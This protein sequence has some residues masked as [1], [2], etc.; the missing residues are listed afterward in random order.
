MERDEEITFEPTGDFAPD[1]REWV[2]VRLLGLK[3]EVGGVFHVYIPTIDKTLLIQ[4]G[5]YGTGKV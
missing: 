3:H 4:E 1:G 5:R 2:N